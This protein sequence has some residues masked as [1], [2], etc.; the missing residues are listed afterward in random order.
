ML[1]SV[2]WCCWLGGRKGRRKKRG[3]EWEVVHQWFPSI[4]DNGPKATHTHARTH[5]RTFISFSMYSF[6]Q[7][8]IPLSSTITF[9]DAPFI[10]FNPVISCLSLTICFALRKISFWHSESLKSFAHS[11]CFFSFAEEITLFAFCQVAE[12]YRNYLL[13]FVYINFCQ[14]CFM[15]VSL[16]YVLSG[17][18]V[19]CWKSYFLRNIFFAEFSLITS[20]VFLHY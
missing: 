6:Q 3:S 12:S 19:S 10:Q 7:S 9:L 11:F 5:A 14:L 15:I 20:K 4:S 18:N 16:Y 8:L 2:L 13:L 1:P 17:Q